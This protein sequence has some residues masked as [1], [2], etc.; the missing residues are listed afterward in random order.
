M[1][2]QRGH[3]IR[4]VLMV[5]LAAGM[6]PARG[7]D[8]P[9]V[10]ALR[11]GPDPAR[12]PRLIVQASA[13]LELVT[14]VAAR[15]DYEQTVNR[16]LPGNLLGG[17]WS[18]NTRQFGYDEA[19]KHLRELQAQGLWGDRL[20]EFALHLSDPPA[21]ERIVPWSEGLLSLLG[22]DREAA[23]RELETLRQE[24]RSFGEKIRFGEHWA[25]HQADYAQ[26]ENSLKPLLGGADPVG[27]NA[28]FWGARASGDFHLLPSAIINGGHLASLQAGRHLHEF[29]A[30]GP[31]LP[32]GTTETGLLQH[33]VRHELSH[34]FVDP[35]VKSHEAGLA[36]SK[37][38]H[39]YLLANPGTGRLPATW[40]EVVGE[41]LL[42]A[43][44]VR[45][46]RDLDPVHAELF[47]TS[48]QL[49]GFL[50][51]RP[52][53]AMLDDYAAERAR[54]PDLAA[55][56]PE[57]IKRLNALAVHPAD[58][59]PARRAPDFELA[60]PGFEHGSPS[61]LVRDWRMLHG[62]T[63]G[64]AK[65]AVQ[66]RV[67][68][69]TRVVHGGTAALRIAVDGRTTDLVALEQGPLAVRAGGSV[70]MSGWVKTEGVTREGLQQ[71][72]CGLYVVFIDSEGNV[73]SRG[74]TDSL[75][76]TNNWTRLSGEFVA[77]SGTKRAFA[78][79]LHG[80]TGTAWFDDLLYETLN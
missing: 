55:F 63:I 72:V 34:P 46:T 6:A 57:M 79:V 73:L 58:M 28:A 74:E 43:Y 32:T 48:E 60:N 49:N 53:L 3:V 70:R 41:H 36:A 67:T 16:P 61:W 1:A 65:P 15:A 17:F 66:A 52:F 30:F 29:L 71:K 20:L 64:T 14:L 51:L 68:R 13:K 9:Y 33:L 69:D 47:V 62:G 26:L 23:A 54:W 78:G 59:D 8:L 22:P 56:M 19:P 2:A 24:I 5:A 50:Y 11:G 38:L 76:G 35:V 25:A 12:T 44:N 45:V 10:A 21:L 7:A 18:A 39:T 4:V 37:A 80:M 27:E 75:V 31:V 40:G 42:R 77:P